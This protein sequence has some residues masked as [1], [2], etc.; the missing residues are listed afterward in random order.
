MEIPYYMSKY[1]EYMAQILNHPILKKNPIAQVALYLATL[2]VGLY[3]CTKAAIW[4]DGAITGLQGGQVLQGGTF[5]KALTVTF[6][7]PDNPEHKIAVTDIRFKN[8]DRFLP[9][10]VIVHT[11]GSDVTYYT[12]TQREWIAIPDLPVDSLVIR[13]RNAS[14]SAVIDDLSFRH[15][16][17]NYAMDFDQTAAGPIAPNTQMVEYKFED[18]Q[19]A[20]AADNA[21]PTVVRGGDLAE[22]IGRYISNISGPLSTVLILLLIALP[23]YMVVRYAQVLSHDL[24]SDRFFTNSDAQ[25]VQKQGINLL[26]GGQYNADY[27]LSENTELYAILTSVESE[28]ASDQARLVERCTDKI[29]L[30]FDEIED[31]L[32][33]GFGMLGLLS[34]SMG[35]LGTVIGMIDAFKILEDTMKVGEGPAQTQLKMAHYINFA[36]V[37]TAIGF[38]GRILSMILIRKTKAR[39]LQHRARMLNLIQHFYQIEGRRET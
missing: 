11:Q 29:Y 37:T 6:Q 15:N 12:G 24:S 27:A 28:I 33:E 9:I 39:S 32:S 4:L 38:L 31:R 10:A 23:F 30:L 36:L 13:T 7:Q 34:L 22:S 25:I 5:W 21:V 26:W 2:F 8:V 14:H 17:R 20:F 18:I 35:L 19:I 1:R 16:N 3:I